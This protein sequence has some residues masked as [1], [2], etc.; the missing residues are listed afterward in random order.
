MSPDPIDSN[1]FGG[2]T[3]YITGTVLMLVVLAVMPMSQQ[4]TNAILHRLLVVTVAY[5]IGTETRF[6]SF[7]K[8]W[9]SFMVPFI[10]II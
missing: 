2:R 8:P 9:L 6:V 5:G 1:R 4:D 3:A 10:A 7:R